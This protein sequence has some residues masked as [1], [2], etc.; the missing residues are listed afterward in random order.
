MKIYIS[1]PITDLDEANQR[2]H[3][4]IVKKIIEETGHIAV[5]PFDIYDELCKI[6]RHIKKPKP[7]YE[8]IMIED[9][10]AL[11]ECDAIILCK[12]WTLS[13][14]CAREYEHANKLHLKIINEQEYVIN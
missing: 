8:Q 3:A 7:T 14:G 10:A 9:L 13:K 11:N 12:G 1:L 6:H 4:L 2:R 5:N